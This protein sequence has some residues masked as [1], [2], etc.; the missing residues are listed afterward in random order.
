[1]NGL[2]LGNQHLDTEVSCAVRAAGVHASRCAPVC[3][4]A[5]EF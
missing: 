4:L 3:D 2:Y 1:M 5:G